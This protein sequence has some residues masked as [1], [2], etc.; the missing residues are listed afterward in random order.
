M[1]IVNL[2]VVLIT[3]SSK[4][5]LVVMECHE[6]GCEFARGPDG[7]ASPDLVAESCWNAM[8]TDFASLRETGRHWVTCSCADSSDQ[9][10]CRGVPWCSILRQVGSHSDALKPPSRRLSLFSLVA[11]RVLGPCF[12]PSEED[13]REKASSLGGELNS[14][15]NKG[16][17]LVKPRGGENDTPDNTTT[18]DEDDDKDGE[19]SP[20][21]SAD[22]H[23]ANVDEVADVEPQNADGELEERATELNP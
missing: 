11:G 17:T 3:R 23:A 14:K 22:A 2:R 1:T 13:G 5:D 21:C 7:A 18:D 20:K 6:G 15:K 8:T 10:D 16:Q 19:K 4:A 12:E 9:P